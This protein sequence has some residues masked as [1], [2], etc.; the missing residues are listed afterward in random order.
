MSLNPFLPL[1]DIAEILGETQHLI[2][3]MADSDRFPSQVVGG[4]KHAW[5]GDARQAIEDRRRRSDETVQTVRWRVPVQD[6]QFGQSLKTGLKGR[7]F[8]VFRSRPSGWRAIEGAHIL[9]AHQVYAN[10][11]LPTVALGATEICAIDCDAGIWVTLY[12]AT[13]ADLS[14]SAPTPQEPDA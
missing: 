2:R 10:N 9:L 3:I 7:T 13:D 4:V 8:L 12:A 5:L 6:T 11:L 14:Y 1:S